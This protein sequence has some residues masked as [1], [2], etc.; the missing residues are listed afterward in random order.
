LPYKI[1]SKK[2]I[3]PNQTDCW[4]QAPL[5]A[6]H[7]QPGQFV[8]L[9]VDEVG[10]RIPLTIADADPEQGTIRLIVLQAGESTQKICALQQ[11]EEILNLMGPLGHPSELP[12]NQKLL[13]VG[14][15]VGIAAILPMVKRAKELGNLVWAILGAKS[16]EHMILQQEISHFADR[17]LLCTDDG[18]LGHKGFV[19]DV[20]AQVLSEKKPAF[21]Q[22]WAVGP[23]VMMKALSAVAVENDFLLWT[24]LNPIMVDGTGM[25]GGCRVTVD[26]QM[27]F[28]C[29]DG[30]EFDGRKVDWVELLQRQAQYLSA[31]KQSLQAHGCRLDTLEQKGGEA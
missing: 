29:V 17:T 5:V 3:A 27:K 18:S 10:E 19:T 14:G 1:V 25:C 26:G 8:V 13:M 31:E 9:R 20:F 24:S 11:G 15:G 12:E 2:N 21:D 4:I 23:T 7:A 28:A 30:P 16:S 6:Q 22:G